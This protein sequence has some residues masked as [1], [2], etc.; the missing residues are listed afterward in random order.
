M[1]ANS[2][3]NVQV[4]QDVNAAPDGMRHPHCRV[5]VD[6][7]TMSVSVRGFLAQHRDVVIDVHERSTADSVPASTP[8]LT[9]GRAM[10]HGQSW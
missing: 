5:L 7:P 8:L 4:H 1:S 6:A 10:R 3:P 9:C 2:A